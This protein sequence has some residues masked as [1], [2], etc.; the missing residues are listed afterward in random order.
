M[1]QGDQVIRQWEILRL[2]ESKHELGISVP[3]LAEHFPCS[4]RTL[5]RDIEILQY[6]GFPL[7]DETRDNE[8]RE[9]KTM[10]TYWKLIPGFKSD[11]LAS[12]KDEPDA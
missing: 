11:I 7:V 2:I 10:T 8:D 6:A 4:K 5:Y 12:R 1:A 9:Q 3:E